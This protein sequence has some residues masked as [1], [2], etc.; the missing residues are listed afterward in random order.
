MSCP[1]CN[2]ETRIFIPIE[3]THDKAIK[4]PTSAA[5][6]NAPK[7]EGFFCGEGAIQSTAAD[8]NAKPV[9][10]RHPCEDMTSCSRS[11]FSGTENSQVSMPIPV[12]EVSKPEDWREIM[13][14]RNFLQDQNE[15]SSFRSR[16]VTL[17]KAQCETPIIHE[18]IALLVEIEKDGIVTDQGANRLNEWLKLQSGSEV[19]GIR[20][21]S[22]KVNSILDYGELTT[23]TAS[24]LEIAI[25]LQVA[26]ERVLPKHIR[27]PI[28]KKRHA[29]VE[30]LQSKL[31]A[32]KEMIALIR[33]IGGKPW[34]GISRG[35]ASDLKYKLWHKPSDSQLSYIRQLGGDPS[36]GITREEASEMVRQLLSGVA[37]TEKQIQFIRDLGENPPPG[38][39]QPDASRLIQQLLARQKPTPRQMMVLRFW[40]KTDLMQSSKEEVASWLDQFY[41]EDRRRKAAWKMFKLANHD[42]GSQHDPASV[43]IGIGESYLSKCHCKGVAH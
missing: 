32:S 10:L 20:F 9:P 42:D 41:N 16:T 14:I 21:L 36:P 26:I 31:P 30:E 17:T 7:R 38:L 29:V 22:D 23:E 18:L 15:T 43:P 39:S 28:L 4:L 27:E 12:K 24:G 1:H 35:E 5:N 6:S 37:A 19:I 33:Q 11:E 40:N 25:D 3:K 34:K 8:P 2:S 13:H